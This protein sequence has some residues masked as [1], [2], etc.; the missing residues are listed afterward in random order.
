MHIM[1]DNYINNAIW[2]TQNIDKDP[3][4]AVPYIFNKFSHE[5][6]RSFIF[7]MI[8]IAFRNDVWNDGL[9]SLFAEYMQ[10]L[11]YA[12]YIASK[13]NGDLDNRLKP[14]P[15]YLQP[16]QGQPI[17]TAA[18]F[19]YRDLP[20]ILTINDLKAPSRV[21]RQFFKIGTYNDWVCI[22][23]LLGKSSFVI[24]NMKE[25][26]FAVDGLTLYTKL[27]KLIDL[28]FVIHYQ[29]DRDCP[30]GIKKSADELLGKHF[31][32]DVQSGLTKPNN[33]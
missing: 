11:H 3:I 25:L 31:E 26:P 5:E 12:I 6:L 19:L 7:R 17:I 1:Q 29:M 13:L 27:S 18:A 15:K 21:I 33:S 30:A 22:L 4:E 16:V 2:H 28:F 20:R 10:T 8:E 9:R 32:G 14:V 23:E 24:E